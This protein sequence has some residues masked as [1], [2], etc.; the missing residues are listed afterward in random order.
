MSAIAR[1]LLR[2]TASNVVGQ[3]AVLAV[4]FALT[5]FV[6]HQLGATSYGLWV[7]VASLIAWGNLLDLGVGAAVT[8]YVAEFRARG[9]SEEASDLIATA[10]SIYSVVGLLVVLASAPFALV[11]PH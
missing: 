3:L 7:L 5:P 11:F 10:L 2:S 1:H 9:R 4:W 6:V 8:K